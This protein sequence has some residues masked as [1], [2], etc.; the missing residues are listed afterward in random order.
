[1][2]RFQNGQHVKSSVSAKAG[3]IAARADYIAQGNAY[4]VRWDGTDDFV[5]CDESSLSD[6]PLAEHAFPGSGE[7][8]GSETPLPEPGVQRG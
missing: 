3:T 6:A 2:F 8:G 5:W 7:P 4:L 1:M